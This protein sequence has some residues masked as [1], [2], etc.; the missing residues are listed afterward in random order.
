ERA[1]IHVSV[2]VYGTAPA[3]GLAFKVEVTGG[4]ATQGV[5]FVVPETGSVV[6]PEGAREAYYLV[7]ILGDDVIED[8][9]TFS[10]HLTSLD[11][12][13]VEDADSV[14][15]IVNDDPSAEIHGRVVFPAG[16][17]PPATPWQI[18]AG[19]AATD[20]IHARKIHISP[21]DLAVPPS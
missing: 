10:L 6:I 3:G 11:G 8:D 13:P 18:T 16:V 9:E 7:T 19:G 5:D 1:E 15:T 17:T 21:P 2:R 4:T 14:I 12:T 20:G